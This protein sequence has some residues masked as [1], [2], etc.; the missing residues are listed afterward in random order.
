MFYSARHRRFGQNRHIRKA[1]DSGRPND[2]QDTTGYPAQVAP[3]PAE[4]P[5]RSSKRRRHAA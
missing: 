3:A 4:Y 1:Q 5:H 2:T